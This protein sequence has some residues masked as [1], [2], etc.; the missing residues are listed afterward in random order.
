LFK[1]S[2]RMSTVS[3]TGVMDKGMQ[4]ELKYLHREKELRPSN[5]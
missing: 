1:Y 2:L 4:S 3:P 5:S